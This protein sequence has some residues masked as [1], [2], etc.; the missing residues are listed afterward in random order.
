MKLRVSASWT[1]SALPGVASGASSARTVSEMALA[2]PV[3]ISRLE[4]NRAATMHGT[5]AV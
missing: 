5:I 4:P 2:G 1:N 3:T